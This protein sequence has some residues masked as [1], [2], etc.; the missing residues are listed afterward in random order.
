MPAKRA[1]TWEIGRKGRAWQ[2]G[3]ALE[4]FYMAP[5][6]IEMVSG[7]LFNSDRERLVMLALLLENLGTDAA[8][9]LGAPEVWRDA[10]ARLR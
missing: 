9:E 3:E 5:E 10:V 4:R 7:K 8:V 1:H 6:K 2:S